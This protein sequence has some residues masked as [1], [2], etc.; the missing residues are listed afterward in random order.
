MFKGLSIAKNCLRPESAL[1]NSPT[2][3]LLS[4]CKMLRCML[5]KCFVGPQEDIK[6]WSKKYFIFFDTFHDDE[7][8]PNIALNVLS[9]DEEQTNKC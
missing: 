3:Y 4:Q 8:T 5:A 1:L 9:F 6:P 2:F 7:K